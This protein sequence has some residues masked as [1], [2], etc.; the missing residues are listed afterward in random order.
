MR[1]LL[2]LLLLANVLYFLWGR[3]AEEPADGGIAVVSETE[4]G[5]ELVLADE[6]V[7]VTPAGEPAA[8]PETAQP[9]ELQAVV[10]RSCVTVGPF[11]E[12]GEAREALDEFEGD[13]LRGTIRSTEGEVFVGHWVQI[14][15]VPD[16]RTANEM[17]GKLRKGGLNEAYMVQTEDEGIKI[18]LGLFSEIARAERVELQAKSME[19][20]AEISPRMREQTVYFVDLGLPPGRGGSSMIE[21]YGEE[22]VL[23]RDA[24]TCP[25]TG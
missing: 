9:S 2:L 23:L 11:R 16:R 24:S 12:E 25:G 15:D 14:R 6:P 1:N 20:A 22:R 18:S 3:F 13:G 4:L 5:P 7:E 8:L 10:G 21:R 17:L 19:L